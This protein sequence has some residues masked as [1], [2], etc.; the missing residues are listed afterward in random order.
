MQL[1]QVSR[2]TLANV[3][4]ALALT[5]L[6]LSAIAFVGGATVFGKNDVQY[7]CA[8]EAPR[9]TVG[10]PYFEDTAVL[11]A[12]RTFVPLGA[13]CVLDS[14]D[15]HVG[16]QTVRLQSWP[17]TAVWL[18]AGATGIIGIALVIGALVPRARARTHS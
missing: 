12:E 1:R 9:P 13:V 16:P 8:V 7:G 18:G 3:G 10:G 4:A 6:P 11:R 17:A 15:D 14:P 5:C 2:R